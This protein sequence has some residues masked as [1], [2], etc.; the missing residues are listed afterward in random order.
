MDFYAPCSRSGRVNLFPTG[1]T[2]DLRDEVHDTLFGTLLEPGIG[3]QVMLRRLRDQT[4]A[5]W[6][7]VSGSPNS[8]CRYC[9]G[10]GYLWEEDM[11]ACYMARNFGGVQNPS[12]VIANQ[13]NTA[14]WG[15]SDEN[16]AIA[17]FE[18][19]VFPNYERYLI[20]QHPSF[21]KLYELKVDFDGNLVRPLVRTGKWS[22]K[23]VTPHRGDQGA[24]IFFE[25]G[26]E[27]VSV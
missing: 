14:K 8:G 21:D 26:L 5:C 9:D 12:N 1:Q 16:R 20:P 15:I 22:I 17:Y 6:D 3:Q 11:Q 24:V 10:E 27:K 25:L 19:L 4:C 13:Q 18:Y 2:F 23:S 7:G